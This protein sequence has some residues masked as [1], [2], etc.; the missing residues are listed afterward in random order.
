MSRS[1]RRVQLGQSGRGRMAMA[2]LLGTLA[3]G[4]E[5]RARR[6]VG[7]VDRPCR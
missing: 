3:A 1:A 6:S 7:M 5:R 4:A 2:V